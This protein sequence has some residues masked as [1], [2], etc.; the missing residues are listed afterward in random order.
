MSAWVVVAGGS[1]LVDAGLVDV[2]LVAVALVDGLS[3]VAGT[4]VPSPSLVSTTSP[5]SSELFGPQASSAM[6]IQP[7]TRIVWI[8]TRMKTTMPTIVAPGTLEFGAISR[9]PVQRRG[10]LGFMRPVA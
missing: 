6:A 5:V 8:G 10:L 1:P 7:G 2:G 4:P 9:R 3:L